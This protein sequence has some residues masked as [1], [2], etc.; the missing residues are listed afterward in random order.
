[1]SDLA[2][3]EV[4]VN[5]DVVIQLHP[6]W[7]RDSIKVIPELTEVTGLLEMSQRGIEFVGE[8]GRQAAELIEDVGR[9]TGVAR[10]GALYTLLAFLA[11]APESEMLRINSTWIAD[12]TSKESVAAVEAGLAYILQDL[13]R[14]ITT[15]R[16]AELAYM[17]QPSFSKHFKR[18]S[19][20][21]FTEV[22]RRLRISQ[23][24]RLLVS[25][26]LKVARIC[27]EVGYT[28]LSNFNRQFLAE[29]GVT[30]R[31]YRQRQ[32]PGGI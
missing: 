4:V 24:C 32:R 18:A 29:K 1:M 11:R 31:E 19:G 5:R 27:E 26:D 21:T 8:A 22:V 28:N 16:A 20:L 17:S 30:P 6:D 10:I 15:Q 23:A 7:L 12:S 13:R 9:C 3:G 14:P 25:T 2:P